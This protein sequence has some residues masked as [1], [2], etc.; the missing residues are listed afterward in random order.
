LS[1]FLEFRISE[2]EFRFL[3][4]STAKF[5]KKIQP[6]SSESKTELDFHFQWGS[7]KL[8]Q[9]IGIPNQ[10]PISHQLWGYSAVMFLNCVNETKKIA[11][12]S[13][14]LQGCAPPAALHP[15]DLW[16][17]Q[18]PPGQVLYDLDCHTY[19]G[20]HAQRHIAPKEEQHQALLC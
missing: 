5:I 1:I 4:F 10:A 8:E 17:Q 12:P 16:R 6:E 9:K 14:S 18:I 13:S 20:G 7:Q 15:C 19:H 11:L 2:S 3:D